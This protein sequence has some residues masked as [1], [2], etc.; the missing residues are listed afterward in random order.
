MK[1]I[2]FFGISS[3]LLFLTAL[4]CKKN[5]FNETE[6]ISPEGKALIK[7]GIFTMYPVNTPLTIY[8]NDT[9][10]SSAIPTGSTRGGGYGYPGG[11]FNTGGNSYADYLGIDPGN[12]KFD[13]AVVYP[14]VNF[15]QQHIF[16]TTLSLI[17]NKKYTMLITDTSN[18]TTSLLLE[19]NFPTDL[20][21]GYAY[22]RIS[23]LIPNSGGLDF[24][25]N[26]SLIASNVAYKATTSLL[27]L[28][29]SLADSFAIRPAGS[30][31]GPARTATVYYRL[32]TNTNKRIYSMVSRGYIGSTTPRQPDISL[33]V[34]K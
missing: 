32:A 34:N 3:A 16:D 17:A 9:K 25:K 19:D 7:F 11:G 12:I 6:R 14:N 28:P 15:I 5:T 33:I 21:E 13:L 29:A 8:Q 30:P 4:A 18:A 31:G 26:D 2:K 27:K 20:E 10:L 23:N 1:Y 24:Y 22:F